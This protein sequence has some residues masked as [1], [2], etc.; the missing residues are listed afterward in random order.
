MLCLLQ[1]VHKAGEAHPDSPYSDVDRLLQYSHSMVPICVSERMRLFQSMEQAEF[2]FVLGE[3]KAGAGGTACYELDY[4]KN[5]FAVTC[6][7]DDDTLKT[8]SAAL[9]DMVDAYGG[10]LRM[11]NKTQTYLN[12]K[13]FTA[14]LAEIMTVEPVA[15]NHTQT[16]QADAEQDRQEHDHGGP[17]AP[18]LSM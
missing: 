12:N 11:K 4:D 6:W 13:V 9:L 2:D 18:G 7:D 16:E 14:R 15:T 5:R 8:A 1:Q 3:I 10:A 17:Q